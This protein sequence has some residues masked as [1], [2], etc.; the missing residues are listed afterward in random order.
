VPHATKEEKYLQ[1]MGGLGW[2]IEIDFARAQAANLR[3][4]CNSVKKIKRKAP[5]KYND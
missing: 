5:Q 3:I 1:A 4:A 2:E